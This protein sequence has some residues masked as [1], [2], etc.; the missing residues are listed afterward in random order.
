MQHKIRN[1]DLPKKKEKKIDLTRYDKSPH[2]WM[3]KTEFSSQKQVQKKRKRKKKTNSKRRSTPLKD[4]EKMSPALF[5]L[6]EKVRKIANFQALI[7]LRYTSPDKSK[8]HNPDIK[9]TQLGYKKKIKQ[10][11]DRPK[12]TASGRRTSARNCILPL[13]V[14]LLLRSAFWK[15]PRQ[16]SFHFSI[17]FSFFIDFL[18]IPLLLSLFIFLFSLALAPFLSF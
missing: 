8:F 6:Q 12:R 17:F 5:N 4:P 11:N 13:W 16:Y 3:W 9:K 15:V 7:Y 2:C 1:T 18:K 14:Y 10:K